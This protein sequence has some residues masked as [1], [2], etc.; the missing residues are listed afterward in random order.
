MT[1]SG[2]PFR[3]RELIQA[4]VVAALQ[5][6]R[7]EVAA[8]AHQRAGGAGGGAA[9]VMCVTGSLH[10]VAAAARELEQLASR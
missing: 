8:L 7:R 9:P 5:R 4:G 3:C 2:P 10:A 1:S 6:A